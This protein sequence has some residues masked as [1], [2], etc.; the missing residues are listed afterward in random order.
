[1][2]VFAIDSTR[3]QAT[4]A[5]RNAFGA[6]GGHSWQRLVTQCIAAKRS[7]TARLAL[8]IAWELQCC[9]PCCNKIR[10]PCPTTNRQVIK[11]SSAA[12]MARS[13]GKGA[14]WPA[15]TNGAAARCKQAAWRGRDSAYPGDTLGEHAGR[16][17]GA[18]GR[19][20]LQQSSYTWATYAGERVDGKQGRGSWAGGSTCSM[21]ETNPFATPWLLAGAHST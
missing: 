10:L 5:Q 15:A 13:H 9:L 19:G 1:M 6:Y 4:C 20:G 16:E 14:N 7:T 18:G 17:P 21:M 12:A 2:G 8:G 11:P 3:S